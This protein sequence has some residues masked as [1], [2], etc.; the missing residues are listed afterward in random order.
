MEK[1][2]IHLD[3]LYADPNWEGP[4]IIYGK[5]LIAEYEEDEDDE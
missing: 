3:H 5:N 4:E 2:L 1:K